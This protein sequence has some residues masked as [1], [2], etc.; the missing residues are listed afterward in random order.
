MNLDNKVIFTTNSIIKDTLISKFSL[1]KEITT[2]YEIYSGKRESDDSIDSIIIVYC[3]IEKLKETVF[4]VKENY[5][6]QKFIL[7][8]SSFIARNQDI[9]TG[10]IMI[11]NSFIDENGDNPIFLEYAVGENFDLNKFG[12]ILNGVCSDKVKD[13]E[14]INSDESYFDIFDH[15]SYNFLKCLTKED[16]ELAVVIRVCIK[17]ESDIENNY[18]IENLLNIVDVMI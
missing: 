7:L 8:G 15:D 6:I 9:E 16:L 13:T 11:P 1:K 18:F 14:I 12:L 4:Y 5:I 17:D 3:K 10:D 2:E